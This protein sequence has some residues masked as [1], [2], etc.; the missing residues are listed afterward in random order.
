MSDLNL[1]LVTRKF[2]ELQSRDS[3]DSFVVA[4]ESEYEAMH[5]HPNPNVEILPQWITDTSW[6]AIPSNAIPVFLGKADE[7]VTKGVICSSFNAG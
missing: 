2:P 4:A 7:S 3:F 5:T 1:Y 6:V